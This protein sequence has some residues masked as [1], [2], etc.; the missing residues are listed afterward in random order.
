MTAQLTE[1]STLKSERLK[2]VLEVLEFSLTQGFDA[3]IVFGFDA[4]GRVN[5]RHSNVESI[6]K[7]VGALERAKFELI[8]GDML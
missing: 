4:D 5:I 6:T 1:L 3:V 7:M 2:S 8:R